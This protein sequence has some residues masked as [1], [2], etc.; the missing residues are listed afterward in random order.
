MLAMISRSENYVALTL[1][2]T[3]KDPVYGDVR[4]TQLGL[5]NWPDVDDLYA[6]HQEILAAEQ[7][8]TQAVD[9]LRA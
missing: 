4:L 8:K 3:Q 9:F 7:M 2:G 5:A 6:R 1:P